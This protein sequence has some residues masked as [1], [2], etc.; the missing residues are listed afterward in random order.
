LCEQLG[1]PAVVAFLSV[2]SKRSANCS[3]L[4]IGGLK[5]EDLAP[6][7]CGFTL[8]IE[9]LAPRIVISHQDSSIKDGE[10][11]DVT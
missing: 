11:L 6:K 8:K 10:D 1:G 7:N 9:D 5:I 3:W 2:S 4:R